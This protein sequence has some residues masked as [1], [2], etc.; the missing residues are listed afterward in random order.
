MASPGHT[1]ANNE[2]RQLEGVGPSHSHLRVNSQ[3][4]KISIRKLS[5]LETSLALIKDK[6]FVSVLSSELYVNKCLYK[7][8]CI[9]VEENT[10]V[11]LC[12]TGGMLFCKKNPSNLTF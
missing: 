11:F 2:P 6:L 1:D 10:I 8:V 12:F 4:S 5:L 7:R 3:G 9:L